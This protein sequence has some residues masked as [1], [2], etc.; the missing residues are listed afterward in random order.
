MIF[1]QL[2]AF[3]QKIVRRDTVLLIDCKIPEKINHWNKLY[4]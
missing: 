2:W 1:E 3:I 4:D